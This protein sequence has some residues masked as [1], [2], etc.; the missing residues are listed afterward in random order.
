MAIRFNFNIPIGE[1]RR[2]LQREKKAREA[3]ETARA[4]LIESIETRNP[5]L[6]KES[7]FTSDTPVDAIINSL[8]VRSELGDMEA[9]NAMSVFSEELQQLISGEAG[10]DAAPSTVQPPTSFG[11]PPSRGG[12]QPIQPTPGEVRG[13]VGQTA[14]SIAPSP[15][16]IIRDLG[17]PA[18]TPP[19]VLQEALGAA[20]KSSIAIRQA[21][22]TEAIRTKQAVKESQLSSQFNLN[23]TAETAHDIS[24]ILV[25]A[26]REGGAGNIVR[27]GISRMV[28][29]GV[30][31]DEFLERYKESASFPG[32]K[33]EIL[34]KLFPVLTQQIGKE[35]SVR[36]VESVFTKL[37][38][39]LPHLRTPSGAAVTQLKASIQTMFRI[40]RALESINLD[41]FDLTTKAGEANF[42]ER[43]VRETKRIKLSPYE[44]K[45]L[46]DMQ[47]TALSPL[48][49]YRKEIGLGTESRDSRL[50]EIRKRKAELLG[51][52]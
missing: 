48:L 45:A 25:A 38:Q 37:G 16:D 32:K 39:S 40:N 18:S 12:V 46:K 34:S 47:D 28:M 29:Q 8:K 26:Y 9:K 30:G 21:G 1:E 52:E 23:L 14:S 13:T 6:F 49:E 35:G 19:Q 33:I 3:A 31:T 36:L 7:G 51:E 43:V 27:E 4:A 10:T 42:I 22:E 20:T 50:E 5:R 44:A 2:R 17:L 11:T 24:E 15:I 41:E